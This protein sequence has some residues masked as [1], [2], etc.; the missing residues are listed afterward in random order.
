MAD[1][2]QAV[3]C[4]IFSVPLVNGVNNGT[5]NIRPTRRPVNLAA[6]S[7]SYPPGTCFP[8]WNDRNIHYVFPMSI[9][10][11]PQWFWMSVDTGSSDIWVPSI[12]ARGDVL[13]AAIPRPFRINYGTGAAEGLRDIDNISFSG[14]KI[15]QQ[16]FGEGLFA[17][18]EMF[19]YPFDGIFGFGFQV[20]SDTD[21]L[22]TPIDNLFNQRQIVRRLFCTKLYH[23]L[24]SA[25]GE[26]C[27]GGC[28]DQAQ[29]WKPISMPGFWQI[30][31]SRVD[32]VTTAGATT[33]TLCPNGCQAMFDTGMGISGTTADRMDAI[34]AT[35]GAHYDNYWQLYISTTQ[36]CDIGFQVMIYQTADFLLGDPFQRKMTVIFDKD[37]SQLGFANIQP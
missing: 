1:K 3:V 2:S 4:S 25:G 12:N 14:L 37:N 26:M 23:T 7:A 10:T 35:V 36:T 20:M 22:S 28:N 6:V 33:L 32:I 21:K 8:L 27:I 17:P 13:N 24:G 16:I 5:V 18:G 30:L 31:M 34:A 9:G 11:P 15:E 29:F 19:N